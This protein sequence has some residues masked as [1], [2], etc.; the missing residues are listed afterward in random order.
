MEEAIRKEVMESFWGLL[1]AMRMVKEGGMARVELLFPEN[2]III[3]PEAVM[4]TEKKRKC[5]H[6][7]DKPFEEEVRIII[8][9][10]VAEKVFEALS[11]LAPWPK[12]KE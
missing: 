2:S 12:T 10:N 5:W 4:V 1:K 8:P 9:L 11:Q 7:D 3:T 6:V